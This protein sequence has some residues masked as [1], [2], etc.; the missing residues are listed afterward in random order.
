MENETVKF[1]LYTFGQY[2]GTI[3]KGRV[4]LVTGL[5]GKFNKA[6]VNMFFGRENRCGGG[7]IDHVLYIDETNVNP[8]ALIYYKDSNGN[9]V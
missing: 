1:S 6:T 9:V 4:V 3:G 5:L 2:S 7:E 8:S